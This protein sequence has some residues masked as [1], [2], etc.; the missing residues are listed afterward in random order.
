MATLDKS[1][2]VNGNVVE[3]SDITALYDALTAGGG[4]NVS[5]SGS[6]TGSASTAISSSY[7]L[8]SSFSLAS[9]ESVLAETAVSSS[10]AT[11]SETA[12]SAN[13]I[14]LNLEGA[15]KSAISIAGLSFGGAPV[16]ISTVYPT[17][18]TP[19]EL[20]ADLIITANDASGDSK[21]IGIAYSSPNLT[22]IGA[23][24]GDVIYQGYVIQP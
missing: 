21:P 8:T 15:P 20:G 23:N 13:S 2:V 1:N 14:R 4:Y 17:L 6:I 19:K 9:E 12:T 10:Y 3:A 7:A 11:T 16:D 24:G 18:P 5:I 22:F